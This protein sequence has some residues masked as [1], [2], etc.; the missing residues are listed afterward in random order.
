MPLWPVREG[1]GFRHPRTPGAPF[2][3]PASPVMGTK[4]RPQ[5]TTSLVLLILTLT[6]HLLSAQHCVP[7]CK[8]AWSPLTDEG[9]LWEWGQ[10]SLHVL[11]EEQRLVWP[12]VLPP[13]G[14][15]LQRV[16]L[17]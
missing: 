10:L 7:V 3:P 8:G 13:G 16:T 12:S 5:G 9:C 1:N 15:I 17:S 4:T 6:K 14:A 2:S 11:A